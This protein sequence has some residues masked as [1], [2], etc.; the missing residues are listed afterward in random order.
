MERGCRLAKSR[1]V[2]VT[3]TVKVTLADPTFAGIPVE[4]IGHHVHPAAMRRDEDSIFYFLFS[5]KAFTR[6]Y[7]SLISSDCAV[8]HA[9]KTPT[10]PCGISVI[11]H[12]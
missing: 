8:N 7:Q 10:S 12:V 4:E 5:F 11:S 6:P 2:T 1:P 3:V 9:K